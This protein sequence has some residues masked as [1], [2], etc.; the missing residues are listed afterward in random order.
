[1]PIYIEYTVVTIT[2]VC[3]GS[4]ECFQLLGD[5]ARIRCELSRASQLWV[6]RIYFPRKSQKMQTPQIETGRD[7]GL[8][9]RRK[10][11]R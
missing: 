7:H 3:I 11:G 5:F 6:N 9:W 2:H 8:E 4:K 10:E 1:M